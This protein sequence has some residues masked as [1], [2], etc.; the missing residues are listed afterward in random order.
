ML[1]HSAY[2]KG[3]GGTSDDCWMIAV[4]YAPVW[5][6]CAHIHHFFDKMTHQKMDFQKALVTTLIQMTY[7]AIFGVIAGLLYMRTGTLLSAIVS[8]MI[9]NWIGLPNVGFINSSGSQ[10]SFMYKYRIAL[11]V[12][13]AIG[14]VVF[15]FCLFPLTAAAAAASPLWVN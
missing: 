1:L 8:H 14:L 15:Y 13:H 10:Y 11:L 7:T 12:L 3:G 9:C 4:V 6:S 2:C 5:F